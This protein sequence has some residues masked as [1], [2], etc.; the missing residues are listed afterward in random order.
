MK[1]ERL[2]FVCRDNLNVTEGAGGT[3]VSGYWKVSAKTAEEAEY[4]FLH[5]SRGQASYRQGKVIGAKRVDYGGAVRYV[6]TVKDSDGSA[7]WEGNGTGEK[8]YGY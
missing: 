6:F 5:Q 4:L 2:H 3:F 8:G 7:D 1:V